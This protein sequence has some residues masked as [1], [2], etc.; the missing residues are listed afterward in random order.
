MSKITK[1]EFKKYKEVANQ[2][3]KILVK[4]ETS[5]MYDIDIIYNILMGFP[6]LPDSGYIFKGEFYESPF[7]VPKEA[8][9]EFRNRYYDH[10]IVSDKI[11]KLSS[12]IDKKVSLEQSF[13]QLLNKN[14]CSYKEAEEIIDSVKNELSTQRTAIEYNSVSDYLKHK[15]QQS[16]DEEIVKSMNQ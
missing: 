7:D 9:E 12:N 6:F 2:I 16:A 1:N 15:K 3:I 13:L 4:N 11:S 8:M 14:N 10:Y 5:S